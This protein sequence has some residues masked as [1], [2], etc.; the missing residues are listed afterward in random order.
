MVS[1]WSYLGRLGYKYN[2]LLKKES[3]FFAF[4]FLYEIW[5]VGIGM[6]GKLQH[7]HPLGISIIIGTLFARF[8][9]SMSIPFLAIYHFNREDPLL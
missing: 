3:R 4:F 7:I 9:T 1:T 2:V 5:G 6:R 8:A